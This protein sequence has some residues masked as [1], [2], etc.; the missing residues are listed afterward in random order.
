M[1][2]RAV[3]L[4][5]VMIFLN[6]GSQNVNGTNDDLPDPEKYNSDNNNTVVYEQNYS[7]V[8][9]M[10]LKLAVVDKQIIDY[11]L[12]KDKRKIIIY[13]TLVNQK[14]MPTFDSISIT[15]MNR[16]SLKAFANKYGD[17]VFL[18]FSQLDVV[19]DS[20]Y[21]VLLTTNWMKS[22]A[23]KLIYLSGGGEGIQFT[24]INGTW[25]SR[26]LFVIIS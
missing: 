24:K 10:S 11:G 26:S 6:C 16:D 2:I 18:R 21:R 25:I 1:I 17:F 7:E 5:A 3:L 8:V 19:N 14:I 9:Q 23:S 12:I 13:D 20:T 15:I 4:L 22:D